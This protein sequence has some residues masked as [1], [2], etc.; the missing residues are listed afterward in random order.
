MGNLGRHPDGRTILLDWAYPGAGPP[1]WDLAWYLSLNAARLPVSKEDTIAAFR[2]ALER[3]VDTQGWFED[4]LAL[5]LLA[6]M[7]AFGWEKALG[8]DDE[9]RWWSAGARDGAR[10]L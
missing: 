4:Q 6:D 9:L 1:C 7:A 3:D 8:A 5:S 10:L 2:T